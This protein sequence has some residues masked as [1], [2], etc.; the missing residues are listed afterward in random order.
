M[1]DPESHRTK[2][3][4]VAVWRGFAATVV[5]LTVLMNGCERAPPPKPYEPLPL[6]SSTPRVLH[7]TEETREFVNA[8]PLLRYTPHH[9]PGAGWFLLDDP[10]DMIKRYVARGAQWERRILELC[11][12]HVLPGTVVLEVGAH[13]GTHAIPL[14]RLVGP[15]G[16]VYAFEPQRKLYRELHHNLMLNGITNVV[17]MRF[18]IG[19]G[20]ARVV[21]MDPPREGNEGGTG[22]GAGGDAA[23][24]RSLDSFGFERVSLVKIDV[25]G[26]EDDV[27][28]GAARTIRRNR[29]TMVVE[30]MGGHDYQTAGPEVRDRI[31]A[32]RARIEAFGYST[33]Q[34]SP[35]NYLALPMS[36]L[37]GGE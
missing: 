6:I 10:E 30:I 32:T 20:E 21:E 23:E 37:P 14:S 5:G 28:A 18:A 26:L 33:V 34:V 25:E 13:I 17:P 9:V 8:F 1:K 24:L 27:I 15:G 16:R 3:T 35:N 11:E 2:R 12:E 29:P 4:F 31:D 19:S 7:D 36:D 22:V